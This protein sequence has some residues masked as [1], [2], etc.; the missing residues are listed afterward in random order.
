MTGACL[1][2]DE[3]PQMSSDL[4]VMEDTSMTQRP[5]QK[6]WPADE[7]ANILKIPKVGGRSLMPLS[8]SEHGIVFS[9][10]KQLAAV[11]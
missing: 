6:Q 11:S 1:Q 9:A 3:D 8:L 5:M 7:C 10:F 4:Q 2:E